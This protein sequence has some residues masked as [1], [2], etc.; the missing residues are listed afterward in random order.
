MRFQIDGIRSTLWDLSDKLDREF[1][2]V[3]KKIDSKFDRLMLVIIGSFI[4][5]G[6]FNFYWDECDKRV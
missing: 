1:G 5:K 2:A 6:G 3:N 4:L